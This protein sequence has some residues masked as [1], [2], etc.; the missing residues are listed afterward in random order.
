M[1]VIIINR[2]GYSCSSFA[3]TFNI[4]YQRVIRLYDEGYRDEQLLE[5][6]REL[7]TKPI[8]I[9]DHKF[10]SLKQIAEHYQIPL[11]SF[12]RKL[13]QGTLVLDGHS[14]SDQL[15]TPII[16]N[17]RKFHSFEQIYKF[18]GIPPHKFFRSL[19]DR[20]LVVDDFLAAEYFKDGKQSSK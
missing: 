17:G 16:I 4:P 3:K 15:A 18:Y 2:K 9:N 14:L 19:Y 13:N 20:T 8:I 6:A 1:K 11:S 7:I 10:Y 12:Y 5:K